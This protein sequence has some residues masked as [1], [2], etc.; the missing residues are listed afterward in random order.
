VD[1]TC[2]C[3]TIDADFSYLLQRYAARSG[4]RA[5]QVKGYAELSQVARETHPAVIF[6]EVDLVSNQ[7]LAC[8]LRTLKED[9]FTQDTPVVL[10][11]WVSE[12]ET[13]AVEGV[14]FYLRKP[15]MY[16]DFL[17][18][19]ASTG[20]SFRIQNVDLLDKKEVS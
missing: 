2:L 1:Q 17:G 5:I 13:T 8:A 14:D 12:Q 20:V 19:L 3:V 6:L 18:A 4:L 15:V 9:S 16:A 7:N 10:I 11:S